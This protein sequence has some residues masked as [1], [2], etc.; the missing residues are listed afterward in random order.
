MARPLSSSSPDL[1]VSKNYLKICNH[2][3][4]C[5]KKKQT[6]CTHTKKNSVDTPHTLVAIMLRRFPTEQFQKRALSLYRQMYRLMN[7]LPESSR[8][9]MQ[10]NLR[11]SFVIVRY[12]IGTLHPDHARRV[13]DRF[14]ENGYR[15]LEL[16]RDVVALPSDCLSLLA[17][18][19]YSPQ[20]YMKKTEQQ[21]Q[22]Q[23]EEHAA[24]Q[25]SR[26]GRSRRRQD[27]RGLAGADDTSSSSGGS[28]T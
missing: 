16:L 10:H 17:K 15:D 7:K 21:Q 13:A 8:R 11:D 24:K 9:K 19:T 18:E 23:E 2:A 28:S 25:D 26:R 5:V 27:K 6:R 3:F 14:L 4:F 20:L 1:C 12:H 22:Q